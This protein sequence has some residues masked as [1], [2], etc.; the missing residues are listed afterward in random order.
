L[1]KHMFTTGFTLT[2]GKQAIGEL[3]AIV[4]QHLT[5]LDRTPSWSYR[6][7]LARWQLSF[8][9]GPRCGVFWIGMG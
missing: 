9:H 3:F 4:G 8:W 1:V 6:L 2:A 7:S 5:D